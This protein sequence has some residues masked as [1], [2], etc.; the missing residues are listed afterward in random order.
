MSH[1][2]G[3]CDKQ[4]QAEIPSALRGSTSKWL[5]DLGLSVRRNG[6][7]AV[8]DAEPHALACIGRDQSHGRLPTVFDRVDN[9]VRYHLG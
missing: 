7:S 1:D 9:K 6:V 2:N 4:T 8:V 5:E 3:T